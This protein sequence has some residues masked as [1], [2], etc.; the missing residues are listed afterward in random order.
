M[1][2]KDDWSSLIDKLAEASKDSR[3]MLSELRSE[4]KEARR[5]IRELKAERDELLAKSVGERIDEVVKKGLDEY[6]STIETAMRDAVDHV[7]DTFQKLANVFMT[8]V[9]SGKPKDGWDL[10]KVARREI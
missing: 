4:L 1:S 8:G 6:K 2:T 9:E 3:E 10:R 5:V 7:D